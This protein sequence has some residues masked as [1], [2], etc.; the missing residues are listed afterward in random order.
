M[1]LGKKRNTVKSKS[2]STRVNPTQM[3]KLILIAKELK[4]E[5]LSSVFDLALD[6]LIQAHER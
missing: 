3:R 5:Y 1:A 6:R 2:I 4:C